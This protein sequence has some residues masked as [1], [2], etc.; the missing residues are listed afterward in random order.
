MSSVHLLAHY[1]H[2][3][4][5]G[6][7]GYEMDL[8]LVLVGAALVAATALGTFGFFAL[9]ALWVGEDEALEAF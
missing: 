2:Q 6:K 9:L 3:S 8:R 5:T 1:G 4:P 7:R